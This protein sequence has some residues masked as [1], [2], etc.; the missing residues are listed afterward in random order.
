MG[1]RKDAKKGK[2]N[3]ALKNEFNRTNECFP[4]LYSRGV[5]RGQYDY[6]SSKGVHSQLYGLR[7]YVGR[8][9]PSAELSVTISNGR[10]VPGSPC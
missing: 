3:W 9:D 5:V 4:Y 10:E 2:L 1:V 6:M 8:A 7:R